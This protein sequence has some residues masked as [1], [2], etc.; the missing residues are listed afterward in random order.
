MQ[1]LKKTA[2]HA[3]H[4]KL[5]AQMVEFGGWD[6]PIQYP[7]GI[8][9]EHLATRKIAGIFDVSHMGR[10]M[11]RGQGALAF[12]Q[13]ALTNNAAAL[14]VGMSHYTIVAD[15]NGTAIDDAYLYYPQEG[16]YLLVVNA[17]NCQKDWDHLQTIL[18]KFDAVEMSDETDTLAMISVQGP[19]SEKILSELLDAGNLPEA[20]R[21]SLSTAT[22]SRVEMLV[23]RTGYTGEARCFELF[24]ESSGAG[25]L[26]EALLE[27]GAEPIGLGARDTL[28][29]EAGLPLY[30][31]EFGTDPEA[32]EI[33]ILAVGTARFAVSLDT[34][35]GDFIGRK[36]LEQQA[37]AIQG[38][39]A[40]DY[41]GSDVIPR[42]VRAVAL[43]GK[44]IARAGSK[45]FQG[46]TLVG[47]I[48]SGTM[49]PFW[50]GSGEGEN[51]QLT[52]ETGKHAIALALLDSRIV[53]REDVEIEVRGRRIPA[54]TVP[55]HMRNEAS[56][57]S[58]AL[59]E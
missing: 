48:S 36:A 58:R 3:Q 2:L 44:G 53:L 52:E 14:S 31:Y 47:Y 15:E 28:R 43:T 42:R 5:D 32:K 40:K 10:F 24:V 57:Y 6:M 46:G 1:E 37:N 54:K 26:W 55:R 30:G 21:N 49:I 11:L 38:F 4:V 16:E 20:K 41:S 39:K 50:N 27:K 25:S 8:I 12:L 51:F 7:A 19:R 35:R 23:A 17:S 33:P 18:G 9:Q 34:E 29:L 56:G 13:Y 45:V 59:V 22:I